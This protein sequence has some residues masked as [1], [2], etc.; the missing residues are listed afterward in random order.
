MGVRTRRR[1]KSA[2]STLGA[3]GEQPDSRGQPHLDYRLKYER[4]QYL[5]GYF[6]CNVNWEQTI[7]QYAY[8]LMCLYAFIL[9]CP[10]SISHSRNYCPVQK[11]CECGL[12]FHLFPNTWASK[13]VV[14][15]RT[16]QR[17][18]AYNRTLQSYG[19]S[20][21]STSTFP[22]LGMLLLYPASRSR[23]AANLSIELGE[24]CRL[25]CLM[26]ISRDCT[27]ITL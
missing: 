6:A 26:L 19:L 1:T 7:I 20:S 8:V 3:C 15:H 22:S 18:S 16:R 10:R 4:E 2:S 13:V 11:S 25:K 24:F 27:P 5:G 9:S 21:L 23:F 17:Y 12:G 14:A